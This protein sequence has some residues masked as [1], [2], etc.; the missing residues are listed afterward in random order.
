MDQSVK[1]E[2]MVFMRKALKCMA[3]CGLMISLFGFSSYAAEPSYDW[4]GRYADEK[5]IATDGYNF[6]TGWNEDVAAAYMKWKNACAPYSSSVI[7]S[8]GVYM[9]KS[10]GY[11][12]T[13]LSTQLHK[14]VLMEQW[15]EENMQKIVPEGT[16]AEDAVEICYK[17]IID[18]CTYEHVDKWSQRALTMVNEGKASCV[19]YSSLFK[20]MV[21]YLNFDGDWQVV[22]SEGMG[23]GTL[24]LNMLVICGDN[25]AWNSIEWIDGSWKYFD[26][27]WDDNRTE[28]FQS[29]ISDMEI[30]SNRYYMKSEEEFYSDGQ[31][32]KVENIEGIV[33]FREESDGGAA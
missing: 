25:H 33:I 8:Y 22:Y 5:G 17:W 10:Y 32:Q 12:D 18:N 4:F 7:P 13:E 14:S 1:L 28:Y 29:E 11:Y 24:K 30:Y 31:H 15:L 9:D 16:C 20:M 3:A 23:P 26:V 19:A 27:T 2:A 21:N 6:Y